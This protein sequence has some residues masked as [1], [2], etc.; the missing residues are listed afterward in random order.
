MERTIDVAVSEIVRTELPSVYLL[1]DADDR[2]LEVNRHTRELIGPDVAGRRFG[3]LLARFEQGLV[4]SE[5]ARGGARSRTVNV[6]SFAGMP[7][8]IECWFAAL[9][10]R[11]IVVGG[12]SP[13]EGELLRAELLRLNQRLAA[14]T[15]ELEK[16]NAELERV[17]AL[18]DRFLGMAAHDLR[19]PIMVVAELAAYLLAGPT[20]DRFDGDER[21]QLEAILAAAEMM[22][23]V[24]DDFLD[25]AQIESGH[26]RLDRAPVPLDRVA[27]AA[28]TLAAPVARRK[29]IDLRLEVP[30]EPVA[31][32]VDR[33]KVQQVVLNLVR[34]A[35]E[36]SFPGAAVT[37]TV[38][39]RADAGVVEVRDAGT[40]MTPEIQRNLFSAYA[41]DGASKTGGERSTGLGLAIARLIVDAHG[42]EIVAASVPG[43]ETVVT[44]VLPRAL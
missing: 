7:V 32:S 4:A 2:V 40:G 43:R 27:A 20:Q 37:V 3:D 17:S 10:E 28:I 36:H 15:R 21:G 22:R 25:V 19:S 16:A 39:A 23:E 33:T 24:V 26:L 18:K 42:G 13:R 30:D 1:L 11:T 31:V 8:S 38:G 35:I 34:N 6:I 41:A 14:R 5:I 9:G 12:S 44:V 29:R